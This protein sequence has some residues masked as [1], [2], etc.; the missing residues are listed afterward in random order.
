IQE[1]ADLLRGSVVIGRSGLGGT[2]LALEAPVSAHRLARLE[3]AEG[4]G[5]GAEPLALEDESTNG[6]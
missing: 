6:V 4:R 2:R 5:R 1:R 3:E